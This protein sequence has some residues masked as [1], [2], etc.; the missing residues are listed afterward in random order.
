MNIVVVGIGYV[1]LV[2]GIC[3]VEIGN[4]VICVD[5]DVNKVK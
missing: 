3:F 4:Y 1:G 2:M 5:I